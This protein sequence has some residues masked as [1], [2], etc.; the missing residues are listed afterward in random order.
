MRPIPSKSRRENETGS[1]PIEDFD[2]KVRRKM[3]LDYQGNIEIPVEQALLELDILSGDMDDEAY[4][5]VKR[6]GMEAME[7]TL[8]DSFE[9]GVVST[10]GYGLGLHVKTGCTACGNTEIFNTKITHS[11]AQMVGRRPAS[12]ELAESRWHDVD[13]GD[14]GSVCTIDDASVSFTRIVCGICGYVLVDDSDSE[15]SQ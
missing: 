11:F 15:G 10:E 5:E 8:P 12:R 6:R 7:E 2:E 9:Y 13:A 14:V 3:C 4:E 1:F